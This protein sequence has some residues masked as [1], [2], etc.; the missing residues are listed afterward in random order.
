M[1]VGP[2][3][4]FE[5]C[6]SKNG[7]K[8]DP[9]AFCAWLEHQT[10]GKWPGEKGHTRGMPT[11]AATIYSTAF[12]SAMKHGDGETS[13]V[14]AAQAALMEAGWVCTN[15]SWGKP[16]KLAMATHS[17]RNVEIF[18]SGVHNGDSYTGDDL[19]AIVDAY[20]ALGNEMRV[21]VK[22]GHTSDDFL[23][24]LSSKMGVPSASVTGDE[25]GQG[26]MALGWVTKLRR[27]GDVLVADL[28]DV[29]DPVADWIDGG[30]YRAV[31]AE[32]YWDFKAANGRVYPRVLCGLALLGAEQP[33]VGEIAG[34]DKAVVYTR[35]NGGNSVNRSAGVK[36]FLGDLVARIKHFA[37]EGVL[38]VHP[39]AD[40]QGN[41]QIICPSCKGDKMEPGTT[42]EGWSEWTC[43]GCGQMFRTVYKENKTQ[44]DDMADFKRIAA[45][46][47]L[48]DGAGEAEIIDAIGKLLQ[49]R[50]ENADI[51]AR[52]TTA[53]AKVKEYS[54]AAQAAV[55]AQKLAEYTQTCAKLTAI[56]G[57]PEDMAAELL[58]L[59][60]ANPELAKTTLKRY[61]AV[62]EAASV[63]TKPAGV[64]GEGTGKHE[65]ETLVEKRVTERKITYAEALSQL[66]REQPAIYK[67]YRIATGGWRDPYTVVQPESGGA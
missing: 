64:A 33:A 34:L 37:G 10:S 17:V 3:E 20:H 30:Q 49:T 54:D 56:A 59:E 1:P 19:D 60:E 27:K 63:I 51:G 4:N 12:V 45:A 8:S 48:G 43:C 40:A 14:K 23:S 44:E 36:Q 6:V 55:R 57:K 50:K 29:P 2:Y 41:V 67:D 47:S 13:A 25:T 26:A 52:L 9:E 16:V 31:S 35:Q 38:E 11:E 42:G 32:L 53:E 5:E 22:L 7:D 61:Q 66:S 39:E 46:L 18:A 28:S 15:D 58:K 65:F 24:E 21:P 62:N